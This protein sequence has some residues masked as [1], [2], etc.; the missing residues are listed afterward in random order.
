[1]NTPLIVGTV[2]I[3]IALLWSIGSWL[4][5]RNIEEP[6]YTVVEKRDGYE[7]RDYAPYIVAEVEVTGSRS[8]SLNQWFR[9]LADS[10][11]WNNTKSSPIAM[12]APVAESASEPV[13]MTVPVMEQGTGDTRRVTFSMPSKYTLATLPKPNNSAVTLREI[14]AHRVAVLRFSWYATNS[15]VARLESQLL[16]MLKRDNI[17]TLWMP[18]YAGYNPPFSAPWIQRNE[19]MVDIVK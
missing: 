17:K 2:I 16:D 7:I 12:T 6:S 8:E 13:A 4:V 1:M 9:L 10:I 5:V 11:F 3:V 19:V 15:R 14:P 18:A